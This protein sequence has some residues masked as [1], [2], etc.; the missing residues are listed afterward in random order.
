LGVDEGSGPRF[1]IGSCRVDE[2]IAVGGTDADGILVE[3]DA[4]FIIFLFDS[5]AHFVEDFPSGLEHF[6]KSVGLHDVPDAMS[7][8]VVL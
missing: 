1:P 8:E 2:G 5:V 7:P 6:L 4:L 3:L